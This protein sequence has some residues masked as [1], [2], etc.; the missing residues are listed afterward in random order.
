MTDENVALQDSNQNGQ[1]QIPEGMV[2]DVKESQ[3]GGVPA[4]SGDPDQ[5]GNNIVSSVITF[6]V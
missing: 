3:G 5:Q 2:E 6:I 1:Q 4:T